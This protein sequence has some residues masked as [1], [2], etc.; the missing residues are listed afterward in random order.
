M[1][2]G[3]HWLL[4]DQDAKAY[5]LALANALRHLPVTMAQKW[6][7]FTALGLAVFAYEGPRIAMDAAIRRDRQAQQ[8][9]PQ[10]MGQVFQ[11]RPPGAAGPQPPPDAPA[12]P[13]GPMPGEMTYEPELDPAV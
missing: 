13:G 3:P 2:R 10:P 7:D 4:N 1:R 6:V 11:F 8:R 9:R 12:A 5:G